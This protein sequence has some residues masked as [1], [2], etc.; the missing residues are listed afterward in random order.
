MRISIIKDNKINKL[1]LPDRID[2]TYWIRD[3]D[4]YGVLKYLISIEANNTI[5]N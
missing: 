5:S 1:N 4:Q 3:L 2:G